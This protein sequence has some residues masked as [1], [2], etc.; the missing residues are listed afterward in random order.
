MTLPRRAGGYDAALSNRGAGMRRIA[1]S[2]LII[3]GLGFSACTKPAPPPARPKP[4]APPSLPPDTFKWGHDALTLKPQPLAILDV[5]QAYEQAGLK[6]PARFQSITAISQSAN[7]PALPPGRTRTL[8]P[9]TGD[10]WTWLQAEIECERLVTTVR[11]DEPERPWEQFDRLR[12]M[13]KESP[14]AAGLWAMLLRDHPSVSLRGIVVNSIRDPKAAWL[15]TPEIRQIVW[16]APDAGI[17]YADTNSML[18]AFGPDQLKAVDNAEL[19][20][21]MRTVVVSY[22][23]AVND[24]LFELY[25]REVTSRKLVPAVP[26]LDLRDAN[27][28]PLRMMM[29]RNARNRIVGQPDVITLKANRHPDDP[30]VLQIELALTDAGFQK[31]DLLSSAWMQPH[32]DISVEGKSGPMKLWMEKWPGPLA[33]GK[34]YRT[35]VDTSL[36]R[37]PHKIRVS[38]RMLSVD[39][40]KERE[41]P[42]L[43]GLRMLDW[44]VEFDMPAQ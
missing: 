36:I 40:A 32:I 10:C 7:R 14:S 29:L 35:A 34:P 28:P 38:L 33:V 24:E 27:Q 31:E 39:R 6:A 26:I 43:P 3:I 23:Q 11:H 25:L 22:P 37:G 2:F 12:D 42:L 1:I 4:E 5:P 20:R 41:S 21:Q 13:A 18:M 44:V 9:V 8:P 30:R 17:D 15:H 16:D 19:L